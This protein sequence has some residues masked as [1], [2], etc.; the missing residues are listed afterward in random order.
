MPVDGHL[1]L[2]LTAPRPAYVASAELDTSSDPKGEFL[3]AVEASRVYRLLGKQGLASTEM[4]GLNQPITGDVGYHVR[5]GKHDVTAYD[6]D[7]FLD[8]MEMHF[9]K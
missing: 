4:P 7:H 1:A 5:S 2:S 9:G 3:S 8:F 6:W